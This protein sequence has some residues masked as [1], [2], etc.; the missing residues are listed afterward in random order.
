MQQ[1][2][3]S[4]DTGYEWKIILILSLT[5]GLVGLDRFILPVLFPCLHGRT[6]PDVS[7]PR[8][9]RR[10][11]CGVLGHLGLRDGLPVRPGRAPQGADPGGDRVLADVGLL[12]HG[13]RPRQPAADPRGDGPGRRAGRFD[14]RGGGRG[15][16]ASQAPRHEQRHLPVHDLTVRQRPRA[17]HRHPASAGH[18]LAHGFMLVGIPGPDHGRG[19]VLPRPRARA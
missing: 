17:D 7:G 13:R 18:R 15:S 1:D 5:F 9:P 4:W 2:G 3:K 16:F 10:H 11:P 14:R 19:D 6:G 12:G 8:Q